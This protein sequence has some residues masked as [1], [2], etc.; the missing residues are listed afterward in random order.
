MDELPALVG[1]RIPLEAEYR[2]FWE[3][4]YPEIVKA[5]LMIGLLQARTVLTWLRNIESTGV[6]LNKVE[7]VPRADAEAA[8]T[9][10]GGTCG[11][12]LRER[13]R[14]V[15]QAIYRISASLIPP[16]IN[17]ID[18]SGAT[19]YK[20]LDV[21][22]F[23]KVDHGERILK[24]QPL[25]IFDDAHCLHDSQYRSLLRWL[26]RRELRV[27]RWIMTRFDG[28]SSSDVL[29]DGSSESGEEGLKR[30]REI[31]DIW[32][33]GSVPRRDQRI[34]FRKMAKGMANRYLGEMEVF[35]RRGLKNLG[36][37][38]STE[39]ETI[40][41]GK[42]NTFSKRVDDLQERLGVVSKRRNELEQGIASY[43][44][45]TTDGGED[46]RL[47]MLAVLMERY[48]RR[49]PQRGLFDDFNYDPKP[50]RPLGADSS[51][52]DGARIHL[53]H[54]YNRPYYFGIDTLCDASSENAE[55]FLQLA[56]RLVS[57]CETQLIRGKPATL[58]SNVQHRLLREQ[59]AEIVKKWSFPEHKL[60]RKL[61]KEI[62]LQC[63]EKSLEGNA[64]LGG[65]ANAF[66]ILQDDF[67]RIPR[68]HPHLADVLKFGIAYNA[69]VLARD[70]SAKRRSWCLV[71]LS[72][73]LLL[74]H[75]LTLKRGGFLER[76]VRDLDRYLNATQ[77]GS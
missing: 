38:L 16:E 72:G 41:P 7:I 37:L 21:I 4:P 28:L 24:L 50:S 54:E 64:S 39:V 22:E 77:H 46:L 40:A 75:G 69:F 66:G 53:L 1:G 43:L 8:L 58:K 70:H 47:A 35:N 67:D 51:V 52:A 36:D 2:D 6:S 56:A 42:R 68:E 12:D 60:V 32:M 61:A 63:V 71:E 15:E 11:P 30:D 62:A 29:L 5:D 26:S 57:Q 65:G 76:S 13:A 20:P 3:F 18:T 55:Q 73:V 9:A 74:K 17:D 49:I 33:Q 14:E 23:L 59:A 19:V 44:A 25:I 45:G 34:S 48:S 31:T 10:I 27:A